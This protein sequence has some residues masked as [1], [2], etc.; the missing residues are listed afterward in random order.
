MATPRR[1]RKEE[2][3][4][5]AEL[6]GTAMGLDS[7]YSRQDMA[8][9]LGRAE[10]LRNTLVV[11][12]DGR[13]VSHIRIVCQQVSVY[14]CRFKVASIGSVCTD[15]AYRG[16]GHAGKLLDAC[17]RQMREK[18]AKILIVSG[19]RALYRRAHCVPAGRV[20]EAALRPADARE[21][22]TDL[23]ARRVSHEE[24]PLLAALHQAESVRFLRRPG[25]ISSLPLW[26]N[27]ERPEL[28]LI[29]NG[30]RAVAYIGLSLTWP[31]EAQGR[32]RVLWE[33]AGSRAALLGGLPTI[34]QTA[35]LNEIRMRALGHDTEL[36]YL[37]RQRGLELEERPLSGTHRIIDL[38]GLMT[39][40]RPY[41]RE[42]LD[43]REVRRLSFEQHGDQCAIAY[44]DQ[45]QE[46][47]LSQA[48]PLVLGGPGAP[49][50]S[51]DLAR[52]LSAVFPIPF[53]LPGFNYI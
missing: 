45:R 29:E 14:G 53:P 46:L 36:I 27:W 20:F 1:P 40:L 3:G 43:R 11:A 34:F 49:E 22:E 50:L 28:W 23:T 8:S 25:F 21:L 7:H 16:R 9:S 44:G 4:A 5:L 17:I 48:A 42:R 13:P 38:P 51:G 31:R 52:A 47:T 15:P 18:G 39:K 10:S 19:D 30:G 37:L 41:L 33:Y 32:K 26:W 35:D 12:E 24:W 6:I 2:A